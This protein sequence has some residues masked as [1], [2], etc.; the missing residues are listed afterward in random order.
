MNIAV[1]H[2][3]PS[4]GAKRTA[5]ELVRRLA[6]NHI[7]DLY[8]HS[9]E[10]EAFLDMRPFV[11]ETKQISLCGNNLKG[12]YGVLKALYQLK[13]GSMKL[14][15]NVNKKNYDL[16]FIMQYKQCNSPYI[17]RYL[18][19]PTLFFCQEPYTKTMDPHYNIHSLPAY[20][21]IF[22][23]LVANI[24]SMNARCATVILCNSLFSR[25]A[26]Y[27]AYGIYPRLNYIGVDHMHFCPLKLERDNTVL[28][29][30]TLNFPLKAQD[31]ILES[32]STLK[33][34]PS[35][36]F[37]YNYDS[38]DYLSKLTHLAKRFGILVVFERLPKQ[39]DLSMAYNK[40]ALTL[41]PSRM[42]PLGLVPL[43][44]MACAT[45]VIGIAEGGIRETVLHN[46][47]GLLTER[48]AVEFGEAIDHLLRDSCLRESMGNRG[49]ERILDS[50]TW[51]KSYEK[52][53]LNIARTM[54]LY[55]TDS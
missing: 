49:R 38:G 7:V 42:E 39:D 50:W 1:F 22:M 11:R 47:T 15:R 2:D 21:R 32:I 45:P 26:I 4:G 31:F 53:E 52:L 27:R 30:G 43:E 28:S 17:L 48:N 41:F 14:A 8:I 55:K 23:K 9:E 19:I 16:A 10:A 12:P 33:E 3:L 5:F 18:K 6:K 34:K 36:R 40:A 44:S 13:K 24:D 46:E 35:V 25:E 51:D 29:V 20:K 54:E 37:I